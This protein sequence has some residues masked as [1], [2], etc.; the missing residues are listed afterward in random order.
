M[1]KRD[2][3]SLIELLI[4]VT[5]LSFIG[6]AS[7]RVMNNSF[8]IKDTVLKEDAEFFQVETAMA[9][10]RADIEQIY[11]PLYY[12]NVK[13][14]GI[15]LPG[16]PL[17]SVDKEKFS[18]SERFA[19]ESQTGHPVPIFTMPDRKSFEFMTTSNR[20]LLEN[21]KQ[22]EY[23]WVRYS[24]ENMNP[25]DLPED[26][27]L[28]AGRQGLKKLVRSVSN[29]NIFEDAPNEIEKSKKFTLMSYVKDIKFLFWGPKKK[30]YLEDIKEVPNGKHLLRGVKVEIT[31]I[32]KQEQ[33]EVI[34]QT[35]R[36]IWPYY[37]PEDLLKLQKEA[38]AKSNQKSKKKDPNEGP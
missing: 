32:N 29:R 17:S 24:L 9:R 1:K 34:S 18:R 35:F 28:P 33:E 7:I 13:V 16:Q 8:R 19:F 20:R 22:S 37:E 15:Q 25:D 12:S 10:L 3:F 36:P 6:L 30:K 27:E 11:S 5:L 2:G 38:D 23:A 31:W 4:G 21:S 14:P 26:E